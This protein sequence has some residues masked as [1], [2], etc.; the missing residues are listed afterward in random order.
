[1][2]CGCRAWAHSTWASFSP[3][4]CR[5]S[6]RA[7]TSPSQPWT[8]ASSRRARVLDWISSSPWL[9]RRGDL[10]HGAADAGVLLD[11]RGA[12]GAAAPTQF[13]G[14]LAEVRLE[15]GPLG[16]GRLANG[17]RRRPSGTN[18]SARGLAGR[19]L[20]GATLP[21]LA[22]PAA[23]PPARPPPPAGPN[24]RLAAGQ[25]TTPCGG[26]NPA[27]RPAPL[28]WTWCF[29]PPLDDGD[30]LLAA[31]RELQQGTSSVAPAAEKAPIWWDDALL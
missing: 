8:V 20:A 19:C 25:P 9:H 13:Y 27:G 12:V 7:S 23:G 21:H 11:A 4:W 1:V 18:A 29:A 5:L 24:Q 15:L 6:S 22:A 31:A 26:S 28:S 30:L 3:M 16:R 2:I 14:A 10:E 17:W